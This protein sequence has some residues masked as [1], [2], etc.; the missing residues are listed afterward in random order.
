M[1]AANYEDKSHALTMYQWSGAAKVV[2]EHLENQGH[3]SD[4][5]VAL[6]A[7]Q[8]YKTWKWTCSTYAKQLEDKGQPV[9][10]SSYYLM[11]NDLGKAVKVLCN[12]SFYQAALVIAKSRLPQ[13][14]PMITDLLKQWAHQ[15]SQDGLY[16]LASKCW[17][18][19][20]EYGQAA[21]SLSKRSDG[22]SLRVASELM[23][24]AGE[25]EKA[26]VLAIQAV[27]AFEAKNDTDGMKVLYDKTSIEEVKQQISAKLEKNE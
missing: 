4:Y 8:D 15:A 21:L 3:L 19:A 11:I 5:H 7:S 17:L 6:A 13:D 23:I 26:R 18:A 2:I 16:E 10:A 14:H 12:A 25:N 24:K 27:D 22:H 20:K 1:E 9:K